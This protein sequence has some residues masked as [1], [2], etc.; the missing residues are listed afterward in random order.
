MAKVLVL[1]KM[2]TSIRVS[3]VTDC[4]MAREHLNGLT[5]PFTKASSKRTRLLVRDP[6][7][8]LTGQPTRAKS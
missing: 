8:G 2:A 7:S 4:F 5:T 1:L 3:Y 6:T